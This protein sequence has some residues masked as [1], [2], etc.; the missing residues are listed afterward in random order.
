VLAF[1]PEVETALQWFHLTH[2]QVFHDGWSSWTRTALPHAGGVG[3][4]EAKLMHILEYIRRLYNELAVEAAQRA[5]RDRAVNQW[6][7]SRN[8]EA[9]AG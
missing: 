2:Q 8:A 7:L 3:E 1:T 6:R 4:Q 9:R 5:E